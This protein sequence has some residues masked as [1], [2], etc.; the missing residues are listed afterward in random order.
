MKHKA[1]LICSIFG[2]TLAEKT[3]CVSELMTLACQQC[4]IVSLLLLCAISEW[5]VSISSQ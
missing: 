5:K 3:N 2:A 1:C 4:E